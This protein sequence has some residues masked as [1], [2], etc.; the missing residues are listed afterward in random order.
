MIITIGDFDPATRT[1]P[2]TFNYADVT[3]TRPVNA[4]LNDD[5]EYDAAATEKRVYQVAN[6]VARK[7]DVGAITNPPPPVENGGDVP[8]DPAAD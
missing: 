5:S 4:C 2:V 7:I 3:H 8:A 6:G 1:V